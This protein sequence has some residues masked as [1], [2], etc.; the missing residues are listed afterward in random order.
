MA[1]RHFHRSWKHKEATE[2]ALATPP[3]ASTPSL[4]S[5]VF[6]PMTD[7]ITKLGVESWADLAEFFDSAEDARNFAEQKGVNVAELLGVWA[8]ARHRSKRALANIRITTEPTTAS[9]PSSVSTVAPASSAS[10]PRP[11]TQAGEISAATL[12]PV[13]ENKMMANE[14]DHHAR[15]L[16]E[17]RTMWRTMGPRGLHW[18]DGSDRV[19]DLRW[20]FLVR[21]GQ[22]ATARTV[23]KHA[24]A[25]RSWCTWVEQHNAPLT[26]DKLYTPDPPCAGTVPRW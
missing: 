6:G 21:G 12:M 14:R 23:A 9:T 5:P 15:V 16:Q 25:W 4:P 22:R 24:L 17:L 13:P 19:V 10:S 8:E 7:F 1:G 2:A 11:A 20:H 3:K 26:D 18:Q